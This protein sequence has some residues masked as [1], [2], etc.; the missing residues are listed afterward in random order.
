MPTLRRSIAALLLIMLATQPYGVSLAA[1]ELTP[2]DPPPTT[3]EDPALERAEREAKLAEERKKKAEAEKAEA[4]AKLAAA[5][6]RLGLGESGAKATAPVG[7]VSGD[8]DKFIET[9]L[10]AERAAREASRELSQRLCGPIGKA[11]PAPAPGGNATLVIGTGMD[12]A[13]VHNYRALYAQFQILVGLYGDTIA[14]AAKVRAATQSLLQEE[15]SC[16]QIGANF[17]PLL[18]PAFAAETV[19]GV[20]DLINLFRTDTEFKNQQVTVTEEMVATYL[21]AEILAADKGCIGS[22]YYPALYLSA[23]LDPQKS[24][25]LKLLGSLRTLKGRGEAEVRSLKEILSRLAEK[26]EQ[27]KNKIAELE[28]QQPDDEMIKK[29]KCQQQR[30]AQQAAEVEKA[31]AELEA[32]TTSVAEFLKAFAAPADAQSKLSL[33]ATLIRAE[34]LAAV[35]EKADTYVLLLEVKA[36]G[37]T[38]IQKN[39]F[40]NARPDHTGGASITA[41]LF[42]AEDRMVGSFSEDYYFDYLKPR[43]IRQ[44]LGFKRFPNQEQQNPKANQDK[45]AKRNQQETRGGG[46]E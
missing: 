12:V 31:K 30:L 38:R 25:L 43:E 28:R 46:N 17:A 32:D 6:A 3:A 44:E 9:Q 26:Q 29:L 36:A 15:P 14:A 37:T 42:D 41:Q 23:K 21:A 16:A 39:I 19:K 11:K 33:T 8:L 7:S 40:W 13:A 35:L 34:R 4:E 1:P 24:E 10:L 18:A 5:K 45:T 22:I 20:A 27:N 2:Q